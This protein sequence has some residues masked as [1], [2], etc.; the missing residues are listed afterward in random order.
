[1]NYLENECEISR[2]STGFLN[3]YLINKW[4]IIVCDVYFLFI[5][6]DL[7]MFGIADVRLRLR[8]RCH[9]TSLKIASKV[10]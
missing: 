7:I 10:I 1:M 3:I 9:V 8:V 4:L 5:S 2:F 6:R